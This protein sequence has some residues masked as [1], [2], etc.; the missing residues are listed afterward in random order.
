M[1]RPKWVAFR[2]G[3]RTFAADNGLEKG[4]F[5]VFTLVGKSEFSVKIFD[6]KTC[7]EKECALTATNTG[8]YDSRSPVLVEKRK[9][10]EDEDNAAELKRICFYSN[11][12]MQMESTSDPTLDIFRNGSTAHHRRPKLQH[13]SAASSPIPHRECNLLDLNAQPLYLL[14]NSANGAEKDSA[15]VHNHLMDVVGARTLQGYASG[16]VYQP[17][18][19][20]IRSQDIGEDGLNLQGL[21]KSQVYLNSM[22]T[23]KLGYDD[24]L[25]AVG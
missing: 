22:E 19:L 1:G 5:L 8:C 10:R 11:E 21:P 16:V 24:M 2:V 25:I 13:Y 6:S 12:G 20:S 7:L 9:Q 15:E 17:H 14:Q 18:P 4:D 23:W 3:W